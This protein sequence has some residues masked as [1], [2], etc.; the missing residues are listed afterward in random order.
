MELNKRV[1]VI[2]GGAQGIGLALCR[3]FAAEGARVVV[4][5]LDLDRALSVAAEIDG[6]GLRCDVTS[7]AQIQALAD[8]TIERYGQVDLFCSNAGALIRDADNL[9][10][11]PD[12]AGWALSWNINV[13]AHVYAARAV[14]PHMLSRGEGY[15]LNMVSAAG[16]LHQVGAA[17]Y[18]ASKHAALA[19]AES[20]AI[21]LSSRGIKVSAICPA[22]V[23]TSL[24]GLD[25]SGSAPP[26]VISAEQVAETVMQGVR[27]ERFMILPHPEVAGYAQHKAA[28]PEGWIKA[29]SPMHERTVKQDGDID[30]AALFVA[31]APKKG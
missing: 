30:W 11:G 13:M 31:A 25:A 23:A 28:D 4:A 9:A 20:L 3:R 18:S 27:D 14:L 16:M 17:A 7:Q 22:Y 21:G 1:V 2:T 5:D 15:L 8:A 6:M 24:I 29:M 10:N 12:D 19:L 26:G